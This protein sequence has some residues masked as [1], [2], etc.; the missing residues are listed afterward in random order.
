MRVGG[1]T[2]PYKGATVTSKSEAQY[3]RALLWL[4]DHF[5]A[6]ESG[7]RGHIFWKHEWFTPDDRVVASLRVKHKGFRVDG[8][9]I[10]VLPDPE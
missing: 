10:E 8:Y 4:N 7:T 9:Q 2:W 6:R 1:Q 3:T 5:A